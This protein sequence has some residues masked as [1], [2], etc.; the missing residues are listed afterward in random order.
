MVGLNIRRIHS[1]ALFL[2]NVH[3]GAEYFPS[4]L[5]TV[6]VR[7]LAQNID[8][9]SMFSCSLSHHPSARCAS[10]ANAVG[11]DRYFYRLIF[12]CKNLH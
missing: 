11:I 10:A 4:I 5:E 9:F 2:I 6:G 3:N 8:N 1:D 12:K 7:V